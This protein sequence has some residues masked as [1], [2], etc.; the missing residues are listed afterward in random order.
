MRTLKHK[1][2]IKYLRE[3]NTYKE[4]LYPQDLQE[5]YELLNHHVSANKI[6]EVKGGS[7]KGRMKQPAKDQVIKGAQ[8]AQD[9]EEGKKKAIQ[10]GG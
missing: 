9:S 1:A 8:Y 7:T 10:R 4:D 3:R 2:V 6:P 5:T